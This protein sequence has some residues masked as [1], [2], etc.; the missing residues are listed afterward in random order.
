MSLISKIFG[1][2]KLQEEFKKAISLRWHL[3]IKDIQEFTCKIDQNTLKINEAISH[4]YFD[5]RNN[6]FSI[7]GNLS[8]ELFNSESNYQIKSIENN[9]NII[10][11]ISS[12]NKPDILIMKV[13]ISRNK[14]ELIGTL[15]NFFCVLPYNDS[16]EIINEAKKL[17]KDKSLSTIEPL[18]KTDINLNELEILNNKNWLKIIS[19]MD[20]Q[21]E[22][23]I[24]ISDF[25]IKDAIDIEKFL[26][27][28]RTNDIINEY[29]SLENW[30]YINQFDKNPL[31]EI[32]CTKTFKEQY[33]KHIST[34]GL[35]IPDWFYIAYPDVTF[36]L[37]TN[38]QNIFNEMNLNNSSLIS[39]DGFTLDFFRAIVN[40][41]ISKNG[42]LECSINTPPLIKSIIL[43]PG[44]G[45]NSIDLEDHLY[46]AFQIFGDK[47]ETIHHNDYSTEYNFFERGISFYTKIEDKEKKIFSI[48]IFPKC[49]AKTI[50][51]I[52]AGKNTFAEMVNVYG[53]P[54][55][56]SST[57][58]DYWNA[59][60][61][62]IYFSFKKDKNNF[63]Y[64][65]NPSNYQNKVIELI[66]IIRS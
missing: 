14:I 8:K 38:L 57:T 36:F 5:F 24:V 47:Y 4:L 39:N 41:Y 58:D 22:Y 52:S 66:T 27:N 18:K 61:S 19:S 56:S 11:S 53:E 65:F 37:Q 33:T 49:N 17:I 29:N 6:L 2:S 45:I 13:R 9:E 46:K 54:K 25:F 31:D 43:L 55:I 62:G 63:T 48:D 35:G 7:H 10:M 59:A 1:I 42:L 12:C 21:A 50:E 51:G 44:L 60:Y 20:I 16:W 30:E 15:K 34:R 28:K 40:Q 3:A 23:K 64:S 32:I 26:A